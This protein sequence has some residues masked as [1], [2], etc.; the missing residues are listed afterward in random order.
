MQHPLGRAAGDRHS[1]IPDKGVDQRQSRYP[2]RCPDHVT[3]R[4]AYPDATCFRSN[5]SHDTLMPSVVTGHWGAHMSMVLAISHA[6]DRMHIASAADL[7]GHLVAEQEEGNVAAVADAWEFY[8]AE[9][10][11]MTVAQQGA[12]AVLEREDPQ[13]GPPHPV[14]Q[15]VLVARVDLVLAH[16]QVRLST[17]IAELVEGGEVLQPGDPTQMIRVPGLL[18]PDVL[19]VLAA[20]QPDLDPNPEGPDPGNW[21]H[22]FWAH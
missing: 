9:G 11:P 1:T 6:S 12:G 15:Q 21:W 7:L 13:A 19:T 14:R 18:L 3:V 4:A 22:V 5:R 20:L 10:C 16:A 8:D 17:S 2:R